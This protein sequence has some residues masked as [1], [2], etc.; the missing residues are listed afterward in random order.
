M[1]F[2]GVN[3]SNKID[4]VNNNSLLNSTT[5]DPDSDNLNS[6]CWLCPGMIALAVISGYVLSSVFFL[7]F[8][9][10]YR[11]KQ[12]AFRCVHIS[13]R[14]GAGE[15]LENTMTAFRHALSTGT[16]MLELD[17]HL[18]KDGQVV[19]AHDGLLLRPCGRSV[20]IAETDYCD[21]PPL[22]KA[23]TL[24]FK[25]KFTCMAQNGDR[26]MPLLREVFQEFPDV[27]V[28]V[29]IK[30]NNDELISKVS[31]LVKE[32]KREHLT[33][34]GNFRDLITQK[35]YHENPHIPLLFSIKR[36]VATVALFYTGLLPFLPIK[37]QFFEVCMPSIFL[38]QDTNFEIAKRSTR[39]Y[40][41]FIDKILMRKS[42][43]DHLRKRGI[44]VYIWVLNTEDEFRRAFALGA[45]GVMTDFPTRLREFLD[46]NP[47][48]ITVKA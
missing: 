43:F 3:Q 10:L 11:K 5:G 6:T 44:Q 22:K 20:R 19:V 26:K 21:L 35:C 41:W 33:V 15:N 42:L 40:V 37:E 4:G 48:Y 16:H 29:D 38:D 47:H 12:Q 45:D 13:H 27:V 1:L 7:K 34:W 31:D 28:N 2:R 30:E 36:V 17:C 24:D 8:P 14:G 32:F 23:L 46:E 39:F 25:K 18:S 9:I